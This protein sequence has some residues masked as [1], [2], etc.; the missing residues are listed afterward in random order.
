MR[1]PTAALFSAFVGIAVCGFGAAWMWNARMG[2]RT[3]AAPDLGLRI[4]DFE[5]IDQNGD[6]ID[7]G[8]LDGNY[9]VAGFIFTNCPSLCPLMTRTMA[10][11][12]DRLAGTDIRL[13]SFSLDAERDTPEVMRA[14]GEAHGADFSNWAFATGSTAETRRIVRED[15]MLVVDDEQN[16]QVPTTDGGT[17]AN[18][19]HPTRMILIGPDRSVLGLYSVMDGSGLDGLVADVERLVDR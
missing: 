9:T 3:T 8:V 5:L 4:S 12:Q 14:F 19:L 6:P 2:E 10:D 13:L 15:L 16:N 17:M 11:A 18:I 7:A 1:I